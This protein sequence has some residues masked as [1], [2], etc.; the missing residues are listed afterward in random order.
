MLGAALIVAL[1]TSTVLPPD[2]A[3]RPPGAERT[4]YLRRDVALKF[5][6]TPLPAVTEFLAEVTPLMFVIFRRDLGPGRTNV[7]ISYRG[8]LR[9]AL[10]RVCKQ[11]GTAWNLEGNLVKIGRAERLRYGYFT[12]PPGG[13][14]ADIRRF[15]DQTLPVSGTKTTVRDLLQQ[16]KQAYPAKVSVNWREVSHDLRVRA[17]PQEPERLTVRGALARICHR[18]R[19]G[20]GLEPSIA[21]TGPSEISPSPPSEDV[22]KA[23]KKVLDRPVYVVFEQ[24]PFEE[25]T[26]SLERA[27]GEIQIEVLNT[28]QPTDTPVTLREQG[29]LWKVLE[30]LCEE[31]GLAWAGRGRDGVVIG[32]PVEVRLAARRRSA[33]LTGRTRRKL[34]TRARL[35]FDDA[36]AAPV[37]RHLARVSG[38]H[39]SLPTAGFGDGDHRVTLHGRME[40]E[41]ALVRLAQ[42][43]HILWDYDAHTL[44][45]GRRHPAGV[46]G[47]ARL[48]SSPRIGPVSRTVRQHLD[49]KVFLAFDETPLEDCIE[50]MQQTTPVNYMLLPGLP[51]DDRPGIRRPLRERP[52]S[53]RVE[54]GLGEALGLLCELTRTAWTTHGEVVIV[55]VPRAIERIAW[56]RVG[57]ISPRIS[58]GPTAVFGR[59]LENAPVSAALPVVR[60]RLTETGHAVTT[61]GAPGSDAGI[62]IRKSATVLEA[63]NEFC[64][65]SGLVWEGRYGVIRM[66]LPAQL[67]RP[68]SLRLRSSESDVG[69]DSTWSLA[70][71]ETP[72]PNVIEFLGEVTDFDTHLWRPGLAPDLSPI[73]FHGEDSADLLLDA[74]CWQ[75]RTAWTTRGKVLIV[76]RPAMIQRL[77]TPRVGPLPRALREEGDQ[78]FDARWQ[79]IPLR[80]ALETVRGRMDEIGFALRTAGPK[81]TDTRIHLHGPVSAVQALNVLCD[82]AG[83]TWRAEGTT[84]HVGPPEVIGPR[85][86]LRIGPLPEPMRRK[87]RKPHRI[88]A[89]EE[90]LP[91]VA[92]RL[93]DRTGIRFALPP[94][95]LPA[96]LPPVT[97]RLEAPLHLILD[98]ISYETGIGWKVKEETIYFVPL[99]PGPGEKPAWWES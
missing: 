31:T 69:V 32:P 44:V 47:K 36:P 11:T 1:L 82:Q 58:R 85:G 90:P 9:K 89:D 95:A 42:Q 14:P 19:L 74:I 22:H 27:A 61:R 99:P 7:T 87:L 35:D 18:S 33:R 92:D 34:K 28:G 93:A 56:P 43:T 84:A 40:V 6:N 98:L 78:T 64:R 66:G 88:R 49:R 15:L 62:S 76:G 17:L 60:H 71:D 80:E 29:R 3:A 2:A 53:L 68:G 12:D 26:E 23:L 30:R 8:P 24:I 25:V 72:L 77:T 54:C 20:W 16:L 59:E 21:F 39:F 48:L 70:F 51:Q 65:Q 97:I 81:K 50:F 45:V 10:D 63:L 46:D 79:G 57:T 83:L 41:E 52:V 37:L 94:R 75:C 13:I 38:L 96:E 67:G 73:T 86:S 5:Q 91:V 4:S 55:G